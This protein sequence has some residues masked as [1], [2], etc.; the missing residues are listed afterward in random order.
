MV[1][2]RRSNSA[3][4]E[5][6]LEPLCLSSYLRIT[7]CPLACRPLEWK[8]SSKLTFAV[9]S[10]LLHDAFVFA[11][12]DK[13]RFIERHFERSRLKDF[14]CSLPFRLLHD[15]SMIPKEI[16]SIYT[17]TNKVK[18]Y[19]TADTYERVRLEYLCQYQFR[20]FVENLL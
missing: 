16:V 13:T 6:H 9:P 10:G 15:L 20:F 18:N 7:V 17:D 8:P 11:G 14:T 3:L 1:E 5:W 19:S 2:T 4:A 12:T